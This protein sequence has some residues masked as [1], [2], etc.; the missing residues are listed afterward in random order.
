MG[1]GTREDLEA[2]ALDPQP[3]G[4]RWVRWPLGSRLK[5][6]VAACLQTRMTSRR[7]KLTERPPT[8]PSVPP[9]G[10]GLMLPGHRLVKPR[11]GAPRALR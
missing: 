5:E 6:V 8:P 1:T 9:A 11:V 7:G 4:G 10:L 2:R 3:S